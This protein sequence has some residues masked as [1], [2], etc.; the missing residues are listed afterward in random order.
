[1]DGGC[2]QFHCEVPV[3]GIKVPYSYFSCLCHGV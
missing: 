3:Y 1:M 2:D